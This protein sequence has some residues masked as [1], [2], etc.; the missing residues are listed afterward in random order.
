M[1]IVGIEIFITW[2]DHCFWYIMIQNRNSSC[3]VSVNKWH[4]RS[5]FSVLSKIYPWNI[6]HMPVVKIIERFDL[7]QKYTFWDKH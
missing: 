4:F 3:I 2:Q 7:E 6:N 1:I 5:N